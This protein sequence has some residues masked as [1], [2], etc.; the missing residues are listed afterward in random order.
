M[1]DISYKIL[2]TVEGEEKVADLGAKL[3]LAEQ[4][5]QALID[6]EKA[7]VAAGAAWSA[8]VKD[9]AQAV[10]ELQQELQGAQRELKNT[11]AD[12]ATLGT[13]VGYLVDDMQQF[14]NGAASGMQAISNNI[15]PIL[16]A[17]PGIGEWAAAIS[18]GAIAVAQLYEHWD[19]LMGVMGSGKVK[20]EA[21]EM[22]ELAKNTKRT[23]DEEARY[24]KLL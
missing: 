2:Q 18:I 15:Q 22:A 13:Q 20:T 10:G 6:A 23:A 17:I 21:E 8:S 1:P 16:A 5:L 9:Q 12:F 7:A 11:K 14:K 24:Q 19:K 4:K 3:G